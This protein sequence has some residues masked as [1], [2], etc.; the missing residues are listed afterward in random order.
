MRLTARAA[1]SLQAKQ[2][3]K[4]P[5]SN[6][7][8]CLPKAIK[9]NQKKSQMLAGKKEVFH[10]ILQKV[11]LGKEPTQR[12]CERPQQLYLRCLLRKSFPNFYLI[13]C[14][15]GPSELPRTCMA[16]CSPSITCSL[17]IEDPLWSILFKN[18]VSKIFIKSFYF[19]L[20]F[21]FTLFYFTIQYWFCHTLTWIHH[22]CTWVPQNN[23]VSKWI[24]PV[25]LSEH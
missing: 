6:C 25:V 2:E 3:E 19:F 20:I 13:P 4:Y 23:Y 7:C 21:I 17:S 10:W 16:C 15:R 11:T 8:S 1:H 14:I 24:F 22:G 18:N 12:H 5:A 9:E